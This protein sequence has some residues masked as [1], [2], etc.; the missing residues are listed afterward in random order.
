M[1]K[2]YPLGTLLNHVIKEGVIKPFAEEKANHII[3]QVALGIQA[4]HKRKIIHRDIKLDN[5][6]VSNLDKKMSVRII[7]LGIAYKLI[8]Y[9]N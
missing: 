2:F 5:I 1:T 3:K 4:L 8:D 7:D 9:N 6:V